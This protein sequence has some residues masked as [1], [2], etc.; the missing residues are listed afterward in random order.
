M[1]AGAERSV[2]LYTPRF[3]SSDK[4]SRYKAQ[5]FGDLLQGIFQ[6]EGVENFHITSSSNE[7]PHIINDTTVLVINGNSADHSAHHLVRQI[8]EKIPESTAIMVF[9]DP[10]HH[11]LE[12]GCREAGADIVFRCLPPNAIED[13][14]TSTR[15][16]LKIARRKRLTLLV[17]QIT[18]KRD[19]QAA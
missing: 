14:Q 18:S 16:A 6:G 15:D 17:S 1:S 13:Y 19:Q 2:C 3:D 7:I 12:G 5:T 8:R 4:S 10:P 11:Y 9:L